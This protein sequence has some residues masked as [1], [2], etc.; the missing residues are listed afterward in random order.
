MVCRDDSRSKHGGFCLVFGVYRIGRSER[1][2]GT[3]IS[4]TSAIPVVDSLGGV[5]E[6]VSIF[7]SA[8]LILLCFTSLGSW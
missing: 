5:V 1:E 6:D 3:L 4:V 7:L 2:D 8:I